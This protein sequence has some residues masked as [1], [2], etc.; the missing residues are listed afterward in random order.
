ME[1]SAQQTKG[2]RGYGWGVTSIIFDNKVVNLIA[3]TSNGLVFNLTSVSFGL[4][5]DEN[6][7]WGACSGTNTSAATEVNNMIVPNSTSTSCFN[8]QETEL[9]NATTQIVDLISKYGNFIF[10]DLKLL[11]VMQEGS[12]TYA[13]RLTMPNGEKFVKCGALALKY[14]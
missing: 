13:G 1:I 7:V 9:S 4:G 5:C 12:K 14:T 3:A 8:F 6:G 10:E 2:Y 11:N